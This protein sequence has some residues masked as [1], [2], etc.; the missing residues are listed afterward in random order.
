MNHFIKNLIL[1]PVKL[2]WDILLTLITIIFAINIYC[3]VCATGIG[4]FILFYI[5]ISDLMLFLTPFCPL[6]FLKHPWPKCPEN[7]EPEELPC[8]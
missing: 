5:F 8:L 2:V 7:R 1:F 4:I 6:L 3:W